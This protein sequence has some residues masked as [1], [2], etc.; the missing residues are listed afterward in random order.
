[1]MIRVECYSGARADERPTRFWMGGQGY[2]LQEVL[3][4]WYGP[5]AMFFKVR[6][7]DG[8]LYIL[9]HDA[10]STID[11]WTL[12]AFRRIGGPLR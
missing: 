9:R 5:D 8:N 2:A 4:Q 3:D 6:A 12:E 1:M 10:S 11:E 7:D